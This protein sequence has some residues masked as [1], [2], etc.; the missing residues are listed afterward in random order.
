MQ[1]V[2]PD[3]CICTFVLEQSL[4]VRALQEMLAKSG[5]NSEGVSDAKHTLTTTKTKTHTRA[6]THKGKP[7]RSCS[8]AVSWS[9]PRPDVFREAV[10]CAR[11]T[12][13]LFRLDRGIN[14]QNG[15]ITATWELWLQ[16]GPDPPS[17]ILI[18]RLW[19]Y[20]SFCLNTVRT[21]TP[22]APLTPNIM[23]NSITFYY[24]FYKIRKISDLFRVWWR[25]TGT[26]SHCLCC[27][28]V[29]TSLFFFSLL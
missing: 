28:S 3:L 5:Q 17:W 9:L 15:P 24:L 7:R 26:C 2:P 21:F 27:P 4:S 6:R 25:G 18:R 23:V 16:R 29:R 19:F 22:P 20:C 8:W 11:N 12:L 1:Y 14:E 13:D 10:H